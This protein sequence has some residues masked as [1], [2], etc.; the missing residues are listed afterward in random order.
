MDDYRR[1]LR[2]RKR[3]GHCLVAWKAAGRLCGCGHRA[4]PSRAEKKRIVRRA[5]GR[6]LNRLLVEG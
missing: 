2:R 4:P 5:L 1:E 6:Q 3:G